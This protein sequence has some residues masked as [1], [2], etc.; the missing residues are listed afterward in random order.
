LGPRGA[1]TRLDGSGTAHDAFGFSLAE[2]RE[3]ADGARF[4]CADCHGADGYR[5]ERERCATCHRDDEPDFVARH[6]TAW[7]DDCMACHDG[8]DRFSDGAFDHAH[9]KYPLSGAHR[10]AGCARCHARARTLA[11]FAKAPR[12]CIACHRDDDAHEGDFGTDCGACHSAETWERARFDHEFPLDHGDEGRVPCRTC[13]EDRTT[14][15]SYTCY[16]CH[17][18]TPA[19][20][21]AKHQEEGIVRN[22]EDCT[23]CHPTGQE[24]EGERRGEDSDH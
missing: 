14:W 19:R 22:L 16:G 24:H 1:L 4:T 5:F 3:T 9:T 23:R 8:A 21:R 6:V 10:A 15:K 7:G 2:H 20:I 11:D 17:E 13:H 12:E 18:H